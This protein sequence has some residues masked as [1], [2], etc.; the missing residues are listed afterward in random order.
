MTE[1]ISPDAL[2]ARIAAEDE[3]AAAA[4]SAGDPVTAAA[5]RA[6]ADELRAQLAALTPA[7]KGKKAADSEATQD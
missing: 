5:C 7:K 3:A 1:D 6:V 2:A 4:A